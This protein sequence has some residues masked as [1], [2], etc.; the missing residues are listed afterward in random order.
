MD[1]RWP[2]H[3]EAQQAC[4]SKGIEELSKRGQGKQH[5]QQH[6]VEDARTTPQSEDAPRRYSLAVRTIPPEKIKIIN[7]S[8]QNATRSRPNSIASRQ[9]KSHGVAVQT[10]FKLISFQSTSY[11]YIHSIGRTGR[12]QF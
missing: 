4:I 2:F 8:L 11:L 6:D 3:D 5:E 1:A 10:Y 7:R 12:L 9:P